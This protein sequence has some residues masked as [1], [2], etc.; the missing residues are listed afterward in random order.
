MKRGFRSQE[1]DGCEKKLGF[2]QVRAARERNTLRHV[3]YVLSSTM[4]GVDGMGD[5]DAFYGSPHGAFIG[6]VP[7]VRSK[8]RDLLGLLHGIRSVEIPRYLEYKFAP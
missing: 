7:W 2:R 3:L 4:K 6:Q 8:R 1:S 5:A